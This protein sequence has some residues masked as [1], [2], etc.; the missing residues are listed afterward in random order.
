V[1]FEV[2]LPTLFCGHCHCTM[3]RR[4]HGA[5]YVTWIGVPREQLRMLVGDA[6]L[7]CYESSEHGQ[8][9]FCRVC[10]SSLFCESRMRP[11]RVDIVLANMAGPVDRAPQAHVYFDDRAQWV[12]VDDGL[13]RLGG[14]SGM[15]PL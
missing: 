13:P 1:R 12:A 15:D 10:G 14:V 7:A 2:T 6:T 5:A 11:D 4:A 8:R 3:C 9:S